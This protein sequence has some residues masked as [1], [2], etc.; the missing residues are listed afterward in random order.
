M[1]T[2]ATNKEE[3]VTM[4]TT[5]TT[6]SEKDLCRMCGDFDLSNIFHMVISNKS[7]CTLATVGAYCINLVAIDVAHNSITSLA[8]LRNL[9]NLAK[10]DASF[11]NIC[12]LKDFKSASLQVGSFSVVVVLPLL[13]FLFYL[14][15]F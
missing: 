14:Y 9:S 7:I 8:P 3:P 5:T 15:T 12:T 4:A 13:L 2:V 10:I 6:M 11:N 1:T